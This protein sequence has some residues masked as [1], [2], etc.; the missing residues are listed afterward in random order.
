[1]EIIISCVCIILL[2]VAEKEAIKK[3]IAYSDDVERKVSFVYIYMYVYTLRLTTSDANASIYTK[4][5][6]HMGLVSTRRK[7]SASRE[8]EKCSFFQ[9]LNGQRYE[10]FVSVHESLDDCT[11]Y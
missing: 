8:L 7:I 3:R 1:M 4:C 2:I 11:Q 9:F 6:P 5:S 10:R